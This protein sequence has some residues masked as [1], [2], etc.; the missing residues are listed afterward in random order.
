LGIEEGKKAGC[1]YVLVINTDIVFKKNAIDR[2]VDFAALH[3]ESVMWTG[4]E[5]NDLATLDA[6][7]E[8]ER[9]TYNPH[10]SCFMVKNDFF[11]NAGKFD[12]NFAPSYCEDVDMYTRL[13]F[14]GKKAYKY[15]GSL[16][17]H[18]GSTTIKSDQSLFKSNSK[19]HGKCQIYFLQKWGSPM[20]DDVERNIEGI[21][22]ASLW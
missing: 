5:C 1:V 7:P 20:T 19:T 10:Y 21:L 16:F 3:P 2:L 9:I 22:Q 14:A 8:T 17:Y 11:S 4:T 15:H 6:C 12:E 13:L 18:F